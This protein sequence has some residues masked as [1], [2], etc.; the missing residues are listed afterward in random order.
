[1][2]ASENASPDLEAYYES[3]RAACSLAWRRGLLSGFNGNV[4]LREKNLC[5]ITRAGAA[6]G[7]LRVEDLAV[8]DARTGAAR[9]G[10]L[11]SSE[12]GMHM[13]IYARRPDAR[14]VIHCHPRHMLALELRDGLENFLDAPLFEARMLRERLAIVPDLPP[15]TRELAQAVGLAAQERDA[16]WMS[17][18]GLTCHG[19]NLMTALALAEELDHLAAVRLLAR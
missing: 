18:H 12:L 16:V 6:K 15:G 10:P 11:P 8:V 4:S 2:P 17:R 19:P 14:A 1:M 3:L 9:K 5:C 7:F 13:E